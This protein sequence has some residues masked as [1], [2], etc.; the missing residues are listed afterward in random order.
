M[1]VSLHHRNELGPTDRFCWL[2]P[3]WINGHDDPLRCWFKRCP[4]LKWHRLGRSSP[5]IWVG[6][7]TYRFFSCAGLKW[8][9]YN[10]PLSQVPFLH[11]YSECKH[12]INYKFE[13]VT[14]WWPCL[15]SHGRAGQKGRNVEN[16]PLSWM[17]QMGCTIQSSPL[18]L[19]WA[20]LPQQN[21]LSVPS[22][23]PIRP[24]ILLPWASFQC[25][26][27]APACHSRLVQPIPPPAEW[28]LNYQ[29]S[30]RIR[31]LIFK[32]KYGIM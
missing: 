28:S 24:E 17:G 29:H 20:P 13:S 26:N 5:V 11:K 15:S 4:E 3:Q 19:Q 25:V 6:L 9:F 7:A 30:Y 27:M 10:G 31:N 23:W 1:D 12:G 22:I 2:L 14:D 8:E 21:V 32:S 18:R 16:F